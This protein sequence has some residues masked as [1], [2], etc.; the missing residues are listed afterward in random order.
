MMNILVNIMVPMRD[1][2]WLATDVYRPANDAAAPALVVRMPYDKERYASPEV[3]TFVKAGYAVVVQDARGRFASQGDFNP[4]FQEI[5]DGAD[6]YAWVAQQPWCNGQVGTLGTSY[7]G[8]SQW[9][10]A[11]HMPQAVRAMAVLIA[12]VDHYSDVAYRGGVLNLGSMLYWCSMMAIGEQRRRLEQGRASPEDVQ[13]QAEALGTLMQHYE[14]LPLAAMP[15][16]QGVSPHFFH[17]LG[18]P[19]YD[20]YWQGI[21][22][23]HS[24]AKRPVSPR[25]SCAGWIA[26]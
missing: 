2:I 10:A 9:L 14:T 3:M 24:A 13:G 21:D 22:A 20:A 5:H 6:C 11:P 1:G 12:P 26:G 19:T 18:H 7:L 17:W 16:L 23:R 4:N 8:Q 25:C 15:H